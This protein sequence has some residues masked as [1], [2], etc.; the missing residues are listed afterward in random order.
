MMEWIRRKLKRTPTVEVV[1]QQVQDG[2]QFERISLT[3][4][5]RWRSDPALR[6]R[7]HESFPDDVQ[8]L[9]HDGE[10]RRTRRAPEECWVR[11]T[12]AFAGPPRL[13]DLKES[14]VYVGKLLNAP[15]L[16]GSIKQGDPLYFVAGGGLE[17][18]LQITEQYLVERGKWIIDPCTRCGMSECLD[19]PSV[20]IGTRFPSAPPGMTMRAFS[21]FCA[22]CGGV[23]VLSM[24]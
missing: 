8:V 5:A 12:E 10:P 3:P 18:P 15:S 11:I 21:A 14:A 1:V 13:P 16:L 7:L 2:P 20:M 24:K 19:P 4:P 23:Q 6:G 9:V 17:T 22:V